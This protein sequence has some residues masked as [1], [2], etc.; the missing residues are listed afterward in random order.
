MHGH[1]TT[2]QPQDGSSRPT[3]SPTATWLGA[4]PDLLDQ[5][6]HRVRRRP[7]HGR[8]ER[9]LPAPARLSRNPRP[10]WRV[11][12]GFHP[13][14]RRAGDYGPGDPA[15]QVAERVARARSFSPTPRARAPQRAHPVD[16]RFPAGQPGSYR[17]VPTSPS[18][19]ARRP[20]LKP[21]PAELGSHTASRTE[22]L[23]AASSACARSPTL[24]A[25]GLSPMVDKD[26]I[27]TYANKGYAEWF[28][29]T[30]DYPAGANSCA[31]GD[32]RDAVRDG[33]SQPAR[34]LAGERGSYEYRSPA[35]TAS[36]PTPAAPQCRTWRPTAV[37]RLLH[38]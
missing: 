5:G 1:P 38:R 32:R 17:R 18:N 27:Y 14:Q 10:A 15:Q 25:A 13:V 12:R 19:A 6:H 4:G 28:G 2:R 30:T 3:G 29:W 8:G 37:R 22:A 33:R 7:P 31:R 35:A 23:G 11:L 24:P 36:P 34:A 20:R 21:P 26:G 9:R 16:P